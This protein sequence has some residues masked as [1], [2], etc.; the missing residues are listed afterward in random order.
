[1]PITSKGFEA[2]RFVDIRDS[3]NQSLIENLAIQL[4]T[5]PDTVLGVITAIFSSSITNQEE[6]I[7]T[8]ASNLDIDTAEGIYLDKLAALRKLR[9]LAAGLST[10]TLFIKTTVDGSLVQSGANFADANANLYVAP[11]ATPINSQSCT[12]LKFTPTA[13]LGLFTVTIDSTV[14]TVN[15]AT[16][17]SLAG[18]ALDLHNAISLSA[19]TDYSVSISGAVVTVVAS[20]KFN[21]LDITRNENIAFTEVEGAVSVSSTELGSINPPI[22]TVTTILNNNGN[23]TEVTNYDTFTVGRL[24]ETDEELRIRFNRGVGSGNPTLGS[25][26]STLSGIEGVSLVRIFENTTNA[27]DSVGRPPN[28]YECIVE[29]GDTQTIGNTIQDTKPA[30]IGTYGE[31]ATLVLDYANKPYT[32][33]WSRPVLRYINVRVI[34]TIYGEE[35]IPDNISETI[36]NVVVANGDLLGLDTDIIPQRFYGSIYAATSGLGAITVEV[37]TSLNPSSATPDDIAYTTN[38]I[39]IAQREKADFDVVRVQVISA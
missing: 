37:G 9:R 31:I 5:S 22:N 15:F 29:G 17:G 27:I 32:V 18:I 20:N 25:I 34:Y 7:Q 28:T 6:L 38:T 1:M 36:K 11:S 19:P 12:S 14:F 3:I 30:A 10:G 35:T 13:T 2:R 33:Y 24:K 21:P 26:F 16:N 39:P 4:D 8:V 23:F